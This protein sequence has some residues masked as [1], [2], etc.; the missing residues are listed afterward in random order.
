MSGPASLGSSVITCCGFSRPEP[1]GCGSSGL[2]LEAERDR[3]AV[4]D[5][6]ARLEPLRLGD[7]MERPHPIVALPA[8]PGAEAPGELLD[9]PPRVR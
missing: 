4:A 3:D 9:D 2:Q 6:G 8:V 5:R 1:G 7:E